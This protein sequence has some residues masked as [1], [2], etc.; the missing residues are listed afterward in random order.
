MQT[1]KILCFDIWGNYAH[2][3]TFYTTSSPLSFAIPPRTAVAGLL[4][5][6]LGFADEYTEIFAPDKSM[7]GL[8]V[9]AP[10]KKVRMGEKI[11]NTKGNYWIPVKKGKHEPRSPIRREFVKDPK[12]RIYVHHK[13]PEIMDKLQNMLIAHKTVFTPYLGISECIASFEFKGALEA[14]NLQ[15]EQKSPLPPFNQ[16]GNGW[17][18]IRTVIPS[19]LLFSNE[20]IEFEA[21]KQY[22]KERMPI[23]M[24]RDR[25]VQ[26]YDDVI[27]ENKGQ[28]IKA[29]VKNC[30]RTEKGGNLILF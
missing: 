28:E 16:G 20:A 14:Q 6:I 17:I 11:I 26:K 24:N 7:I 22:R 13:S 15:S 1:S 2:F 19:E 8:E 27:F 25:V 23:Y 4:G 30:W 10:I 5:A 3:R 9:A 12:Y 21:G 18:P 29:N